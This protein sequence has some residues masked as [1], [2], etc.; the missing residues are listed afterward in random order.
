MLSGNVLISENEALHGAG[1]YFYASDANDRLAITENTVISQNTASQNG[2]GICLVPGILTILDNAELS[3]NSAGKYGGR[4][5]NHGNST[6]TLTGGSITNNNAVFGKG[7]YNDSNL[8]MEGTRELSNGVCIATATSTVKLPHALTGTST[9]QLESSLYVTPNSSGTPIVVGEATTTYPLLTQADADAFLKP[10]TGFEGWHIQLSDD[11]TQVL[12]API[13]YQIQYENLMG[14]V[15]PNPDSY[16]ITTLT[17]ELLPPYNI[18]GY[19]F[20]GWFDASSNNDS[21]RSQCHTAS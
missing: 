21:R 10:Q 15:N 6:I 11:S 9:I 17:I 19:D 8:Y 1:I 13:Q 20:L 5:W 4:I 12:L 7:I 18:S 14:A 2:G 3:S 16:T